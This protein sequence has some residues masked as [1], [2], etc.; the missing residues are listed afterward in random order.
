MQFT[1][2]HNKLHHHKTR[3]RLICFYI[4]RIW[5]SE[6]NTEFSMCRGRQICHGSSI[7]P[8][9]IITTVSSS[10]SISV[11][12]EAILLVTDFA[13]SLDLAIILLVLLP[14][15]VGVLELVEGIISGLSRDWL[16]WCVAKWTDKVRA[17]QKPLPQISHLKGF[18]SAWIYLK[19]IYKNLK[20]SQYL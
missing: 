8:D 11:L 18:S 7:D 14:L 13:S 6:T 17:W 3:L 10:A 1:I 20:I 4:Y 15:V 12:L 2:F 19:S 9:Y 5:T 16:R